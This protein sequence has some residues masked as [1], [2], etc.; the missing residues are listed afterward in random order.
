MTADSNRSRHFACESDL[1]RVP[2][3]RWRLDESRSVIAVAKR[4]P[5]R[6][7]HLYFDGPG[8]LGI[9]YEARTGNGATARVKRYREMLGD[10]IVKVLAGDFEGLIIFHAGSASDIPP[11]FFKTRSGPTWNRAGATKRSGNQSPR[12]E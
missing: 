11:I 7:D 9:Y 10:R 2:R 4:N 3:L 12:R 8:L 1:K 6:L 5:Y